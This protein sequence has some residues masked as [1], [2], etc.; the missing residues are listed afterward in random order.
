VFFDVRN[1]LGPVR[2]VLGVSDPDIHHL[3]GRW[4]M[5][6]SSFTTRFRV[7]LFA[8]ALPPGAPLSSPTPSASSTPTTSRWSGSPTVAA[9]RRSPTG[10]PTP[11]APRSMSSSRAPTAKINWLTTAV[12][13]LAHLRRP[14]VPAPYHLATGRIAIRGPIT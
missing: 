12:G 1:G 10:K 5:F 2:N 9:D 13:R 8:A 3:D 4:V 7:A 14:P 6:L 11:T